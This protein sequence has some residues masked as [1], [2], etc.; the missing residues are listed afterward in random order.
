MLINENISYLVGEWLIRNYQLAEFPW[1]LTTNESQNDF[2]RVNV[3]AVTI[4]IL[5][6]QP[7]VLAE[8]A[9]AIGKSAEPLMKVIDDI[10]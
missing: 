8:F 4:C 6:H 3:N 1:Y 2:F 10:E 7:N 9:N 5:R